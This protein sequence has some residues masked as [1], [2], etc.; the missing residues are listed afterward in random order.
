MN[1]DD[2][3]ESLPPVVRRK[4]RAFTWIVFSCHAQLLAQ[5]PMAGHGHPSLFRLDGLQS[6]SE[7]PPNGAHRTYHHWA[8]K[9]SSS[10]RFDSSSPC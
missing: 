9:C 1:D 3:F 8:V 6:V 10:E 5:G 4:V 2:D 7:L